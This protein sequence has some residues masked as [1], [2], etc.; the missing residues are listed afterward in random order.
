MP[1]G[2]AVCWAWWTGAGQ[3]TGG[4]GWIWTGAWPGNPDCALISDVFCV[5]EHRRRAL[6]HAI[7]RAL[8]DKARA[9]G[10]RQACLAPGP[11][12]MSYG[13]YAKYAYGQVAS[14]SVLVSAQQR[15]E[16]S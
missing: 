10:T 8:E 11:E 12:V 16:G 14:R 7:M 5:P 2:R 3:A 6:C 9:L 1:W 13:L 4:R 15:G